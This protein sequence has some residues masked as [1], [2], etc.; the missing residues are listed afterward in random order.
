[1]DV[2]LGVSM[3]PV[4]VRM[5]LVEGADATGV[6][7]DHHCDTLGT[8]TAADQVVAGIL[9]TRDSAAEGAHR[10]AS[11]GVAWTDRAAAAELTRA[12]RANDIDEVILV[13]ELHAASALAQAIGQAL[14][15]ERTAL[16]FLE[17]DTAT[18][19]VVRA[20]DGAVVRVESRS[21]HAHDAVAGLRHMV[22]GLE[23]LA[24]PPQAVFMVGSGID[25]AALKPK[26]AAGTTLTVHAPEDGALALARGAALAAANAPRF[27]AETV[28]VTPGTDIPTVAGIITQRAPAGY[29]APLGYSAMPDDERAG[30]EPAGDDPADDEPVES[31]AAEHEPFMLVGSALM[32][33]FVVGVLALLASLVIT[34]RPTANP[35]TDPGE[36]AAVL[37]TSLPNTQ[38]AE[39]IANPVPV[40]QEAPR[41]IF[42]TPRAPAP[43]ASA[44]AVLAG[45]GARPRS[46]SGGTGPRRRSGPGRRSDTAATCASTPAADRA[47][48][49]CAAGPE[50]IDAD[51]DDY[52]DHHVDHHV[53][54]YVDSHINSHIDRHIDR[55]IDTLSAT[56]C[57]HYADTHACRNHLERSRIPCQQFNY[58]VGCCDY[59]ARAKRSRGV[60][61][62]RWIPQRL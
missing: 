19:A 46:S 52:I 13:S 37:S 51:L 8:G 20:A 45:T 61:S 59:S 58:C 28:G 35:R 53:D 5:V 10:I 14:G 1:M 41:T 38:A 23:R 26:I 21:L 48:V 39:T 55:H 33:I 49:H 29:M 32:T 50:H 34:T 57:D 3:T 60:N 17:R 25:V 12:L 9:G 54:H 27:E 7:I 56:V 4:A 11:I 40:V 42:V 6:T 62:Q 15:C 16:M 47:P 2:V 43:V 31:A 30:D 22:A 44:P 24:Q 18:L 36:N